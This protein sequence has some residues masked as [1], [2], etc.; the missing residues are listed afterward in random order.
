MATKKAGKKVAKKTSVKKTTGKS[1]KP[2]RKRSD[3]KKRKLAPYVPNEDRI[4]RFM[5]TLINAGYMGEEI[6]D[7]G[8]ERKRQAGGVRQMSEVL[9][10]QMR[11]YKKNAYIDVK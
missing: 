5:S 9:D 11:K 6:E 3:R 10:R 1:D 7:T 4:E 8:K 2:R